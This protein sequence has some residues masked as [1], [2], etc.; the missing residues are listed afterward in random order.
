MGQQLLFLSFI[1][2]PL[3]LFAEEETPSH[4]LWDYHPLHVSAQTLQ[5]AKADVDAPQGGDLYFGKTMAYVSMIVPITKTSY[6][7]PR[8]EWVQFALDWDKNPKFDETHF[9]YTQFALLFYSKGMFYS[10]CL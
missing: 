3:F 9:S 10:Y 6:F 1:L 2:F 7:I 4:S 8:V 5:T